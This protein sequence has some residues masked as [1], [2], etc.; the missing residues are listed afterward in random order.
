ML[1]YT[2]VLGS[3]W[4]RYRGHANGYR[5]FFDAQGRRCHSYMILDAYFILAGYLLS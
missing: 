4:E 3:F 1:P 2:E 5:V